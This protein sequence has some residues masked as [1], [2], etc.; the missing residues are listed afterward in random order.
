MIRETLVVASLLLTAFA[1]PFGAAQSDV[2][3][4]NECNGLVDTGCEYGGYTWCSPNDP[5]QPGY[6][7]TTGSCFPGYQAQRVNGAYCGIWI[8]G[9]CVLH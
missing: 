8:G 4:S 9:S 1:A 2:A 3:Q 7:S 5:N 6:E